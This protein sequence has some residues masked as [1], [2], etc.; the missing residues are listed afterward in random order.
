M[1]TSRYLSGLSELLASCAGFGPRLLGFLKGLGEF[2]RLSFILLLEELALG[3]GVLE[4]LLNFGYPLLELAPGGLF[5][6][7]I[8]NRF[9]SGRIAHPCMLLRACKVTPE[10]LDLSNAICNYAYSSA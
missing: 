9:L 5:G 3:S 7:Q 2:S 1:L 6:L 10:G 8:S 4:L